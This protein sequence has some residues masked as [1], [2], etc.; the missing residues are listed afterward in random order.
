[1]ESLQSTL[2]M[3]L[4]AKPTS[5]AELMSII[6]KLANNKSPGHDFIFNKVVK[7]LPTK[8]IVHLTHIYNA[9]LRLSYFPTT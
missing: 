3:A 8:V 1:M 9:A 2:P 7:N 5:P 4:P 6:K